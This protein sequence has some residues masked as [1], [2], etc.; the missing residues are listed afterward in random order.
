MPKNDLN[1]YKTTDLLEEGA[2]NDVD[3]EGD[4][5]P[6]GTSIVLNK[7]EYAVS[8][9]WHPVQN[10][11]DPIQEVKETASTVIEGADLYCLRNGKRQQY[12]I[13]L[14]EE[15][16]TSR[17]IAA[18]AV[19]ADVLSDKPST[20]AVFK[21]EEG[22]WFIAIRNDLILSEEDVLYLR[23]EDAK[24]AFFSMMAVPDWGYKF[25][26]EEWGLDGTED[27]DLSSLLNLGR[28]VRLS[29]IFS[30]KNII[31]Y[32]AGAAALAL[33][34]GGYFYFS[35]SSGNNAP[36]KIR[37]LSSIQKLEPVKEKKKVVDPWQAIPDVMSML[38][39]CEDKTYPFTVTVPG[40]QLNR[41]ICTI[42]SINIKWARTYGR[43]RWVEK[44]LKQNKIKYE[45]LAVGKDGNTTLA[46]TSTGNIPRKRSVPIYSSLELSHELHDINN[47][48]KLEAYF[49]EAKEVTAT[50]TYE[51][52][53]LSFSSKFAPKMWG[54]L[55][56]K[57]PSLQIQK[58]EYIPDNR[59]W[60]YEA[61]IYARTLL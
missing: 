11:D 29:P 45:Q 37:P 58:I 34:I 50:G 38:S 54:I 33:I 3:I 16:H 17:Q 55:L 39:V 30:N 18:A 22:W 57:F 43:V 32:G 12:G 2:V 15:G 27:R 53:T 7:K 40:W 61:I 23:E 44:T 4:D 48:T 31:F 6:W 13:G 60:N 56:T 36:R 28:P 5:E 21:V 59:T 51:T 14:S 46:V 10:T 1:S 49:Q 20:V 19:L 41:V 52:M 24:R 47:A 9:F 25:A 8:L 26:P 42:D 35:N